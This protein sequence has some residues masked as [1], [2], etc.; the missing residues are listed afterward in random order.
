MS[1]EVKLPVCGIYVPC[2]ATEVR[3][4]WDWNM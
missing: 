4:T 2:Y 1:P 3:A